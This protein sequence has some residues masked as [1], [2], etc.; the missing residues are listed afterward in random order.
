MPSLVISTKI[1]PTSYSILL[2]MA[3]VSVSALCF[4]LQVELSNNCRRTMSEGA[5]YLIPR[6]GSDSRSAKKTF[7]A[8]DEILDDIA[9][10]RVPTKRR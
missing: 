8:L 10:S 3:A 6:D 4:I 2:D 1:Y 5:N 9:N 7:F